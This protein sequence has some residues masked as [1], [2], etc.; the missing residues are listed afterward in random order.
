MEARWDRLPTDVL[1]MIFTFLPRR[2]RL[3]CSMVSMSWKAALNTPSLWKHMLVIVD[4]DLMNDPSTILFTREYHKFIKS[5]ELGWSRPYVPIRWLSTKVSDVVKRTT[6]YF[7]IL[8]ENFVQLHSLK[9]HCWNDLT[10]FRKIVYHIAL[11][12]KA[13]TSLTDLCF[14]NAMLNK[15]DFVRFIVSCMNCGTKVSHLDIRN[16]YYANSNDEIHSV[17]FMNCME[18]MKG[19][20]FIK[21]D[22]SIFRREVTHVLSSGNNIQLRV[23]EIHIHNGDLTPIRNEDWKDICDQL[24]GLKVA[25]YFNNMLDIDGVIAVLQ[26][27]IPLQTFCLTTAKSWNNYSP[28]SCYEMFRVLAMLYRNTLELVDCRLYEN[29]DVADDMIVR[30]LKDCRK[31][32]RFGFKGGVKRIEILRDL[33]RIWCNSKGHKRIEINIRRMSSKIHWTLLEVLEELANRG[34]VTIKI[35]IARFRQELFFYY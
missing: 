35:N 23:V 26:R 22:Y 24:S 6:R 8:T 5:L 12:L 7:I 33:C 32:R 28:N 16:S 15:C 9:M 34:D 20:R 4:Q 25:L 30:L 18:H 17:Q 27:S 11:F 29:V 1:I 10:H 19:L 13:Q 14:Y 21:V 3:A 2:E 31:L